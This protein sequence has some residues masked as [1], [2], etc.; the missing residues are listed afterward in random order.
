MTTTLLTAHLVDTLPKDTNPLLHI[1]A[2]SPQWILL[3]NAP[4]ENPPPSTMFNIFVGSDEKKAVA[5]AKQ[6]LSTVPSSSASCEFR[7]DS[8]KIIYSPSYA[9]VISKE[10]ERQDLFAGILYF[11]Y[12]NQQLDVLEKG[13]QEC[14]KTIQLDSAMIEESKKKLVKRQNHVKSMQ[15]NITLLRM[16][17]LRIMSHIEFPKNLP[18]AGAELVDKMADEQDIYDR[19][20]IISE[21]LE[22]CGDFYESVVESIHEYT[23]FYREYRIECMIVAILVLE[24]F[25]TLFE[26]FY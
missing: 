9:V 13:I 20:E 22:F 17:Y 21:Q 15:K 11:S 19:F 16:E 24:V 18:E 26:I 1:S 12:Y 3:K 6:C 7:Q 25:L 8:A 2:P 4:L 5:E 14:M 23:Y 10:I